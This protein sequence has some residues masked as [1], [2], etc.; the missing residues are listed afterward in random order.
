MSYSSEVLADN[1]LLHLRFQET[2]GTTCANSG[3]LGGN[4]TA[5]G[6][7]TRNVSTGMAGLDIGIELDGTSG[8]VTYPDTAS[9]D[10]TGDVT[11]E[12]WFYAD[13]L[14]DRMLMTKGTTSSS[15]GY[16]MNVRAEGIIRVGKTGVI[17]LDTSTSGYA[18]GAWIHAAFTR[19]GNNY[20]IYKNGSS[21]A[22]GTNSTT[23]AATSEV[24]G[25]GNFPIDGGAFTFFD[26]KIDEV[27]VYNTA[28]SG[29]RIAAHY[30]ARNDSGAAGGT[31]VPQIAV[32]AK[33]WR[34]RTRGILVP[35]LWTPREELA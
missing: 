29:A 4:A 15:A 35:D 1:P 8:K 26:G 12:C 20:T 21:F 3:S 13:S 27:A 2:A 30:A 25:I 17:I 6:T 33:A 14:Q 11:Y 34:R 7:H 22:T 16:Y 23:I 31:F 19:S 9:L 28:L 10:I 5:A 18:A 24:F 32:M